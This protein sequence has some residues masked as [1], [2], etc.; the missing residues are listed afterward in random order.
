MQNNFFNRFLLSLVFFKS[1]KVETK[2]QSFN[3]L[4]KLVLSVKNREDLVNAVKLI[5]HFNQTHKIQKDSPEFIYFNKMVRLMRLVIR[6]KEIKNGDENDEG[7]RKC[8]M[9]LTSH[10][11]LI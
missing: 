7:Q 1:E 4:K 8:E 5:N 6:K 10:E 2:E 11:F 9:D 3:R